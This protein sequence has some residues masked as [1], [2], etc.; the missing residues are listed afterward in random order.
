MSK[1]LYVHI[2]YCKNIC[3]YC[4][5]PKV[6][7]KKQNIDLYLDNLIIELKNRAQDE[8]F[9]HLYVGGGTPSILNIDQVNFL[10]EQIYKNVKIAKDAEITFEANPE[11]ITVE[12]VQNLKRHGVNRISLG[13]QTFNSDIL[14]IINRAHNRDV[15]LRAIEILNDEL[16]N[17]NIDMIFALPTQSVNNLLEDI[18]VLKK[19]KVPHFSYYSL[20][21]EE[22]TMLTASN[23]KFSFIDEDVE[24][25][26]FEIIMNDFKEYDHYEISNFSRDKHLRSKFNYNYWMMGEYIGI[27][28]GAH[29]FINNQRI[30]NARKLT[31]YY[32]GIFNS[33]ITTLTKKEAFEEMMFLMLRTTE[34]VNFD[35]IPTEIN[36]TPWVEKLEELILKGLIHKQENRYSLSKK[37]LFLANEVFSEMIL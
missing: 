11:N 13:V 31:D 5:F 24:A 28:V 20:I 30:A 9:S 1:T 37:G 36:I 32:Q 22:N 21:I 7:S 17:F 23:S 2:P 35:K 12:Y 15:A 6:Y 3:I 18:D 19:L 29:S 8:S 25:E 33:N 10:F 27:G 26:M 4:D 14:K 34:G 16:D